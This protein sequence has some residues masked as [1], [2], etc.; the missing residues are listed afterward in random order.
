[1]S[2]YSV[3]LDSDQLVYGSIKRYSDGYSYASVA[4]KVNDNEIMHINYEWNSKAIPEFAMN[5]MDML[6]SFDKTE[7]SVSVDSEIF[8]RASKVMLANAESTKKAVEVLESV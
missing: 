2:K 7:A 5:I 1:M 4:M 3:E 8:E 6:K